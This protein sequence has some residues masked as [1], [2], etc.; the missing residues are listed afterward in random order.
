MTIK[1]RILALDAAAVACEGIGEEDRRYKTLQPLINWFQDELDRILNIE[2]ENSTF[3]DFLKEQ[4][5]AVE[6]LLKSPEVWGGDA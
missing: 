2:Y 1:Q 3:E 5:E 6:A 4:T